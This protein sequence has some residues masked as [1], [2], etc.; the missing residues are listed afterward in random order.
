MGIDVKE[1]ES[2]LSRII[3]EVEETK[4]EKNKLYQENQRLKAENAQYKVKAAQYSVMISENAEL[5]KELDKRENQGLSEQDLADVMLDA[6]RVA[7][8]IVKKA[9]D[10]TKEI[11]LQRKEQL[12]AVKQEGTMVREDIVNFKITI[13]QKINQW[14][15][16]L[17]NLLG[18]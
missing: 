6:K 18:Q 5:K 3:Q 14:I 15:E 17:D 4:Q 8:D 12:D 10:K 7:N 11:E 16:N 2:E 9:Q 1:F 13:D